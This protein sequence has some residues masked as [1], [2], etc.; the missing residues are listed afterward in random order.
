MAANLQEAYDLSNS[1]IFNQRVEGAVLAACNTV[2]AEASKPAGTPASWTEKRFALV[3]Q[4]L[5]R[6]TDV[7][8]LFANAA[9]GST[10]IA[11]A[12]SA[13]A[14]TTPDQKQVGVTD[15]A[16]SSFIAGAWDVIAGVMPTDKGT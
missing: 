13:Q 7:A 9:A 12:Y 5:A 4:A 8:G 16:I 1:P 11:N 6:P 2:G 3:R 15:A 10:S 14:G